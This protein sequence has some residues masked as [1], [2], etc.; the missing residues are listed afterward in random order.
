MGTI[1]IK[2]TPRLKEE[3]HHLVEEGWYANQ[4][5]VV[6]D[7]IRTIVDQRRYKATRKAVEEDLE[8]AKN[9]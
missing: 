5:E 2:I 7:G 9:G 6:R 3:I 4:S 1:T 8:W